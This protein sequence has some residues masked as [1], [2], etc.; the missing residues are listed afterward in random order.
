MLGYGSDW[1]LSKLAGG[2]RTPQYE[3]KKQHAVAWE[4]INMTGLIWNDH[5]DGCETQPSGRKKT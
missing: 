1:L 2:D 4:E 5:M 3:I